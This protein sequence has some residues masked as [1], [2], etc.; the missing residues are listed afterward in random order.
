MTAETNRSIREDSDI[1]GPAENTDEAPVLRLKLQ[2]EMLEHEWT[3]TK[4][5]MLIRGKY[6]GLHEP[7]VGWALWNGGVFVALGALVLTPGSPLNGG[8]ATCVPGLIG[9][10]GGFYIVARR[11]ADAKDY[12]AA[13]NRYEG[14]RQRLLGK[15]ERLEGGEPM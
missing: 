5:S 8:L 14:S 11:L 1:S 4:Q 12:A 9:L 3:K 2:L 6:G 10:A 7:T 13:R 15:L